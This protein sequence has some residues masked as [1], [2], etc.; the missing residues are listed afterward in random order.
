MRGIVLEIRKGR[1]AVLLRDGTVIKVKRKCRVGEEIEIDPAAERRRM[2]NRLAG[3]VTAAA[4]LVLVSGLSFNYWHMNIEAVSYVTID[5]ETSVELACNRKNEVVKIIASDEDSE[6]IASSFTKKDLKGKDVSEV[7][8]MLADK[9]P[10]SSTV[11]ISVS[12]DSEEA[13]SE[14]KKAV[15]SSSFAADTSR[16]VTVDTTDL[17]THTEAKDNN[18]STGR[19]LEAGYGNLKSTDSLSGST[20]AADTGSAAADTSEDTGTSTGSAAES[21]SSSTGVSVPIEDSRDMDL[22][23]LIDQSPR[24]TEDAAASSSTQLGE[25]PVAPAETAVPTATADS[26]TADS[27]AGSTAEDTSTATDS[28]TASDTASEESSDTS[29]S[30]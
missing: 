3:F 28:E 26:G 9:M 18:I 11:L 10:S 29:S 13:S 20:A 16:N 14:L 23:E 15:D 22:Q 25:A 4:S 7:L 6:E 8:D 1:A 27:A 21:G 30:Q 12:S 19:Y 2:R 17:S 24:R 5:G